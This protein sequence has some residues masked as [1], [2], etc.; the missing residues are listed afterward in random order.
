MLSTRECDRVPANLATLLPPLN[1]LQDKHLLQRSCRRESV[2]IRVYCESIE[3]GQEF[4]LPV[5]EAAFPTERVVLASIPSVRQV[6]DNRG[7]K[8][9]FDL[10]NPDGLATIVVRNQEFPFAT[11]EISDAVKTEDHELQRY[12]QVCSSIAYDLVHVKISP[13]NKSTKAAFGG[14]VDFDPLT[15]PRILRD[16]Y[17]FRGA[18]M[19]NW[20]NG[21]TEYVCNRNPEF[22]SCPAE[23]SIELLQPIINSISETLRCGYMPVEGTYDF[24]NQVWENLDDDATKYYESMLDSAPSKSQLLE[25]WNSMTIPP[26]KGYLRKKM[27]SDD[28]VLVTIPRF[29]RDSPGPGEVMS[30]AMMSGA[31]TVGIAYC[32]RDRSMRITSEESDS[33]EDVAL[34]FFDIFT[35]RKDKMPK[36]LLKL[37]KDNWEEMRSNSIDITDGL[38][39]LSSRGKMK[40]WVL[41]MVFFADYL[42]I[43][44][45]PHINHAIK[46]HWDRSAIIGS[47]I[48]STENAMGH[49]QSFNEVEQHPALFLSHPMWRPV[50]LGGEDYVTWAA[51]SI[52]KQHGWKFNALSYPGSQGD[53]AI[54][55]SGRGGLSRQR[56]YCDGLGHRSVEA[57]LLESKHWLQQIGPDL[58]K[59]QALISGESAA[60]GSAFSRLGV[61][62][63]GYTS[64]VAFG[65]RVSTFSTESE[66]LESILSAC[67]GADLALIVCDWGRSCRLVR[68]NDGEILYRGRLPKHRMHRVVNEKEKN[69]AAQIGTN[70][71]HP[72]RWVD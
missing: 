14:N 20:P 66:E 7:L 54:L 25:E 12:P 68:V 6:K 67:K 16:E 44:D 23:G 43:H 28:H 51:T 29:D 33:I 39:E 42:M 41:T 53:G 26:N 38:I 5:F 65:I 35:N 15:I 62:V 22:P 31:S 59:L 64:C 55:P 24:S 9:V 32:G 49:L 37:L 57:L 19:L 63:D 11:F 3:Q 4:F 36:D 69:K 72:L 8:G 60:L 47:E 1:A 58:K 13:H 70:P 56:T 40:K 50:H 17:R 61:H 21:D 46:F 45:R 52:L 2:E 10:A 71:I 30:Y 48:G 18:F 27:V 34:R